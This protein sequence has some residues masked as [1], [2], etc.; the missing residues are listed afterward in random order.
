MG[1]VGG[2]GGPR[3]TRRWGLIFAW[4]LSIGIGFLGKATAAGEIFVFT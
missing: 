4:L 1:A 3:D 2:I